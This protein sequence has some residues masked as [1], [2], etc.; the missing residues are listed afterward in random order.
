[1]HTVLFKRKA[2]EN[3]KS[4]KLTKQ[5]FIWM[6]LVKIQFKNYIFKRLTDWWNNITFSNIIHFIQNH[7]S[8]IFMLRIVLSFF[9]SSLL[10]SGLTSQSKINKD[11]LTK[12]SGFFDSYYSENIYTPTKKLQPLVV[13]WTYF[14]RITF[15]SI[16]QKQNSCTFIIVLY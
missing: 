7:K 13:H 14:T 8:I 3:K 16:T 9:L 10:C 1:M 15:F 2:T 4:L 5:L 12:Y 11:N 6:R